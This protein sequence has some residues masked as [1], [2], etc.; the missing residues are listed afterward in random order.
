MQT[1]NDY[2]ILGEQLVKV[3][4]CGNITEITYCSFVSKGGHITKLDKDHYVNNNTGEYCEI[5]HLESRADDIDN[6]RRT[7]KKA[8]DIINTNCTDPDKIRWVTLTYA[9]NM[10]DPERLYN[11]FKLFSRAMR[12]LYGHFEYIAAAEPQARGAWH[13]H[14]IMIFPDVAPY[15]ENTVC[16]AAWKQGFVNI[17]ACSDVD[18]LGAYLSAYMCNIDADE[19]HP[20]LGLT[21][22]LIEREVQGESKKYI[23]GA[24]LRFYPPGF[25]IFRYSRGIKRPKVS[26]MSYKAAQAILENS[27]KNYETLQILSSEDSDKDFAMLVKKEYYKKCK[28]MN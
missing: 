8:R 18:N 7:M 22:E 12:N 2:K 26:E 1:K 20:L 4:E 16:A 28:T 27:E 15:I 10:R 17:Q 19:A 11:D 25:N 9:E 23:K 24:R 6:V 5:Q 21:G 13:M 14:V 3:N